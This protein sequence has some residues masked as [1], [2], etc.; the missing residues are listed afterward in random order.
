MRYIACAGE[1]VLRIAVSSHASALAL[2]VNHLR[3]ICVIKTEPKD[4]AAEVIFED[5]KNPLHPNH[6]VFKK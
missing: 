6:A 5:Y 3:G 1:F 2:A 4:G